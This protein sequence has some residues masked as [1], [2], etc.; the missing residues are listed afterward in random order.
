MRS[1]PLGIVFSPAQ[2]FRSLVEFFGISSAQSIREGV[3]RLIECHFQR[4]D[5]GD[6]GVGRGSHGGARRRACFAGGLLCRERPPIGLQCD[7]F[8]GPEPIVIFWITR[9]TFAVRRH[10][11]FE[12]GRQLDGENELAGLLEVTHLA[13]A[14]ES[15]L[16]VHAHLGHHSIRFIPRPE[17]GFLPL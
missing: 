10:F 16:I 5:Q 15:G 3:H 2:Q 12:A 8:L 11:V 7:S 1:A 9:K 4:G 13:A 14:A 17:S 6:L